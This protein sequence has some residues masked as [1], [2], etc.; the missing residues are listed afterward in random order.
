M[1]K[2]VISFLISIILLSTFCSCKTQPSEEK[3]QFKA[4]FFD[5]FDT[6]T[7]I[8]GYEKTKDDFDMVVNEIKPIFQKYHMLYDIYHKYDGYNNITVINET[9]NNKHNIV[10]VEPEIIELLN[11]SKELYTLTNCRFNIAM[12]SVLSIWQTYRE[13]GMSEPENAQLPPIEGLKE[14]SNHCDIN[15]VEIDLAN[16]TVYLTDDKMSLDVGAVAKGYACEQVAKYLEAKGITGYVIN[17]GGNV[18][19][20]GTKPNGEKWVVGIEN[21]DKNNQENPYIAYLGLNNQSLVTSGTY[22]RFYTVGDKNYHHI[23]DPDT[24]MPS[25]RYMSVSVLAN[26]SGLADALS[27]ALFNM[28]YDDGLNLINKLEG[29]EALW[30]LPDGKILYSNNFKDYIIEQ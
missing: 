24:L 15:N 29:V 7:V 11:F 20:I 19:T 18:R 21:P 30:T 3:E 13:I 28:S 6:A 10:K 12:G 4:Y 8:T 17:A 25:E 9:I 1:K 27:T 23:I 5:W 16:Y 22:Q 26:E 14:A 2:I